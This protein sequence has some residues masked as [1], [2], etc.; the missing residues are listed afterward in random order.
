MFSLKYL[1]EAKDDIRKISAYISHQSGHKSVGRKVAQDLT[2]ACEKLANS[3]FL[4][5][6][7]R[8]EIMPNIRSFPCRNYII[9]FRHIEDEDILQIVRIFRDSQDIKIIE[10]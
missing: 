3:P 6:I 7:E 2:T 4:R 8:P 1:D 5:G 10:N 9:F